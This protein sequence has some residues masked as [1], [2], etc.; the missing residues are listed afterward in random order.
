M[1]LMDYSQVMLATLFANIG[2]HTNIEMS[3]D[4]LRHMFL[5]SLKHNRKKFHEEYGEIVICCD[6]K[7]SWRREAFPYYKANR[8]TSR[9]KSDMDWNEVFRIM[10]VIREEMQEFFP[11][12]VIQIDHCEADDI[13]GTL[14]HEYGTELNTGSERVLILSGDKDFIQLQKYSNVDQYNPAMKKYVR[15]DSPNDYLVEHIF[16]GDTGDGVPNILSP[17]NCLVIGE[18]QKSMTAKR[19]ALFKESIDNMDEM[20]KIRY[21][22]NKTLI[23]L[24]STPEEYRQQILDAFNEEK[25]FG[26]KKLFNYFIEKRLKNL[27]TD[28]QD[29]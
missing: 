2:N 21:N 24:E 15:H 3:E 1:I 13:I 7:N 25:T 14:C 19:M 20:T 5:M 22:R 10:G 4:L 17:D 23:D 6:G 27:M 16:K 9:E 11:Y 29:F 18:R 12:K 8:R 26:R 28:I